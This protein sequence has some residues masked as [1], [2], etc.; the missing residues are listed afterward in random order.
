MH[1]CSSPSYGG[2]DA[3]AKQDLADGGLR[4]N[5]LVQLILRGPFK[6]LDGVQQ[7]RDLLLFLE[8]RDRYN[9]LPES[10]Q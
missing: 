10:H 9:D 7:T 5:Q 4:S 6:G 2:V 1:T 3:I 8:R